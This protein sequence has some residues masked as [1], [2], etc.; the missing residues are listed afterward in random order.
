[1]VHLLRV[2]A[3]VPL[4]LAFLGYLVLCLIQGFP[5]RSLL[6]GAV[7]DLDGDQLAARG[8][9]RPSVVTTEFAYP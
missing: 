3:F 8:A 2:F 4:A 9:G 1:M 6:L 7:E 5:L